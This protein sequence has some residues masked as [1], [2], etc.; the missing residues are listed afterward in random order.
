MTT[1]YTGPDRRKRP[2]PVSTF[3][4]L[5]DISFQHARKLES[6]KVK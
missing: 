5:L 6:T 2:R 1:K 3:Q 4:K